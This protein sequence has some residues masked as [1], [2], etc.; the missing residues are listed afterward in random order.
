M[1]TITQNFREIFSV[2]IFRKISTKAKN[3]SLLI[4]FFSNLYKNV[5]TMELY[6][7]CITYLCIKNK[8]TVYRIV[9]VSNLLQACKLFSIKKWITGEG[10]QK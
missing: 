10:G 6:N 5:L 3:F 8:V 9:S 4:D 7:F 1:Q 2:W